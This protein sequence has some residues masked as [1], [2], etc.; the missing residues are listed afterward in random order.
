MSVLTDGVGTQDFLV[1]QNT[2]LVFTAGERECY[3]DI[4]I[5]AIGGGGGPSRSNSANAGGGGSGYL[6]QHIVR[7]L[8]NNTDSLVV[9]V[10]DG[11]KG[12]GN[13]GGSSEVKMG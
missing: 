8:S 1:K 3:A 7:M 11:G 10:G 6:I 12:M 4:R 13:D 5:F 2:S 9:V